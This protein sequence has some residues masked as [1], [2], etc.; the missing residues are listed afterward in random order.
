MNDLTRFDLDD[1]QRAML[2]EMGV[3][4]WT[5]SPEAVMPHTTHA[6][7][8]SPAHPADAAAKLVAP[9][10]IPIASVKAPSLAAAP[11][12]QRSAPT[13]PVHAE[14]PEGLGSM[15]WA[16]LQ[17]TAASCQACGLCAEREHSVFGMGHAQADWLVVG[18]SPGPEENA[19]GQPFAGEAGRLLDN[20]LKAMGLNRQDKGEC[21]VYLMHATQCPTPGER[22]PTAQEL[23]TCAAYVARK[24]ALVQPRMMLV[25]GRF[26]MQALLQTHEPLGKMRGQ[27]HSYQGVPLVVT[28]AP[29]YLLRNP[30]DKGKAWADLCLALN[31]RQSA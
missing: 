10:A 7:A 24:V 11:A 23:Q 3:R 17:T 21:G 20:M 5:P 4:V 19:S 25:M 29:A 15:D 22:N 31:T 12:A 9:T 13:V 14:L 27:V 2:A 8:T 28:Y 30:G 26:A 16:A 1:R 6:L 18:D